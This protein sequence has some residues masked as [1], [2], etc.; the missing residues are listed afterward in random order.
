MVLYL[1]IAMKISWTEYYQLCSKVKQEIINTGVNYS[2]IIAIARGGFY[3]GDYL[4]RRLK[5]PLAIVITSSY[6]GQRKYST[7]VSSLSYLQ[8]LEPDARYLLVDDL[9]D[10]GQTFNFVSRYL[11]NTY[12]LK[13]L[14]TACIWYKPQSTFKPTYFADNS[15]SEW[16][17]QPF[18]VED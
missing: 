12:E 17:I 18:E 4:S 11:N 10:S 7:I 16:I 14:D 5:I 3:L 2:Q 9:T 1:F 13:N 8:E 15:V 6:Q